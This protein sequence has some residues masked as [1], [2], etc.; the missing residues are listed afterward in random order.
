MIVV[1]YRWPVRRVTDDGTYIRT[2][3]HT[4]EIETTYLWTKGHRFGLRFGIAGE[5]EFDLRTG[6]ACQSSM[7]DYVVP[8][9]EL[10][11]VRRQ[12]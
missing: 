2:K 5:R 7:D 9:H 12:R 11:K 6:R 3:Q 8:P 10:E 1:V 4:S